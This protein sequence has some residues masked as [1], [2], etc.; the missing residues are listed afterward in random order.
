MPRTVGRISVSVR[1]KQARGALS[2]RSAW[3]ANLY[4]ED[5]RDQGQEGSDNCADYRSARAAKEHRK[6]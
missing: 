6:P 2:P 5:E 3:Y 1:G 4:A